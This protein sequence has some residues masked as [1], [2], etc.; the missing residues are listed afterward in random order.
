MVEDPGLQALGSKLRSKLPRCGG[1]HVLSKARALTG[2]EEVVQED[3]GSVEALMNERPAVDR[4]EER[5]QL[6]QVRGVAEQP[7]TLL[8]G[9]RNEA[10]VELFQVA[11]P[12]VDHARAA[13]R[14]SRRDVRLLDEGG[15]KATALCIKESSGSDDSATD[16]ED[17]EWFGPELDEG[18]PARGQCIGRRAA[19]GQGTVL[20]DLHQASGGRCVA[21][22]QRTSEVPTMRT[23]MVNGA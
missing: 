12:S 2:P 23:R 7:R 10:E 16:D 17:I 1:A 11:Q 15:P 5:F 4:E 14:C 22:R 18:L 3:A 8:E 6:D 21:T 9:F 19:G 20:V 13:T